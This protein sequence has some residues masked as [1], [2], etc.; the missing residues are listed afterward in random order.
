MKKMFII[1]VLSF[2]ILPAFSH[3]DEYAKFHGV[4][5]L[6]DDDQLI[7]INN[8]LV[9]TRE[10]EEGEEICYYC[11]Y[12]IENDTI[13]IE[14]KIVSNENNWYSASDPSTDID[15][16]IGELQYVFSGSKLILV[17]DGQ[18]LVLSK[19]TG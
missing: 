19:V 11:I 12:S 15:G 3:E 1:A 17:A 6:E 4:W 13:I 2:A 9:V 16:G 7:F 10:E 8:T 14:V 18:P 5:R